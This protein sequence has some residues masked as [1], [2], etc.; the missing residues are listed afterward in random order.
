MSLTIQITVTPKV[1][2]ALS[3]GEFDMEDAKR[4]FLEIV[5]ALIDS[6]SEKVLFDG[7]GITG[8]PQT[9]ER[10]YYGEFVATSFRRPT[11]E[12]AIVGSP[13]ITYILTPPVLDAERLGETVAVNRGLD[14]KAF[15]N[16][17]EG[18]AWLGL[19]PEDLETVAAK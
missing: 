15:H 5:D 7:R 6:H 19:T 3:E 13:R 16:L 18:I 10:F 2:Y 1:L 9:I 11:D 12:G 14:V 4:T 17:A 8:N